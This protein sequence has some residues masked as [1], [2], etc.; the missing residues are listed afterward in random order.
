MQSDVVAIYTPARYLCTTLYKLVSPGHRLSVH[1]RHTSVGARKVTGLWQVSNNMAYVSI[2]YF[3]GSSFSAKVW[4][5]KK[6][7]FS[8]A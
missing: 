1:F 2:T 6:N 7:Y 4:E 3:L 8:V 5:A